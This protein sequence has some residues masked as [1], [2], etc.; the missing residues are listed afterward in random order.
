MVIFSVSIWKNLH[1]AEK[2]YTGAACGACDKY[3]VWYKYKYKYSRAPW[4]KGGKEC[5]ADP[6]LRNGD[7]FNWLFKQGQGCNWG[8]GKGMCLE[9]LPQFY[10]DWLENYKL[11]LPAL[12]HLCNTPLCGSNPMSGERRADY[13]PES[14]S[15]YGRSVD[16][17]GLLQINCGWKLMWSFSWGWMK[18][19]L[20]W[21]HWGGCR[22]CT[23]L[24]Q[25]ASL[26]VLF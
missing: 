21:P 7:W 25:I 2:I 17:F 8:G 16:S 13:Y 23:W 18:L 20:V 11:V 22:L 14:H 10:Q 9:V 3:Q 19:I 6:N 15:I 1:R 12:L 26:L 24:H 5:A 4:L